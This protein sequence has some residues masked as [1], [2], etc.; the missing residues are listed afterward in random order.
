M[1]QENKSKKEK[2]IEAGNIV[3][4]AAGWVATVAGLFVTVLTTTLPNKK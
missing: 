1:S 2:I 3:K 4:K